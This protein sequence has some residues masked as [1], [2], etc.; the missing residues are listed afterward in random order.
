MDILTRHIDDIIVA[1]GSIV[2]LGTDFYKINDA[3][4]IQFKG[5]YDLAMGV[6]V[7]DNFQPKTHKF[8]KEKGVFINVDYVAPVTEESLKA[9]IVALNSEIVGLQQEIIGKDAIIA[10]KE[11]TIAEKDIAISKAVG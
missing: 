4:K 11:A 3:Y 2:E 1:K 5:K 8:T 6:E 10:A 9:D 7:E